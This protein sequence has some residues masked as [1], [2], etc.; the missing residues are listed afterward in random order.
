MSEPSIF[1]FNTGHRELV[2]V[3]TNLKICVAVWCYSQLDRSPEI[4]E[5]A[6]YHLNR[7]YGL[8]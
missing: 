8:N 4:R 6:Q 3:L 1:S 2:K 7:L 5:A